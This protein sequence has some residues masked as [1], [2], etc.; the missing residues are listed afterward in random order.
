MVKVST[1]ILFLLFLIVFISDEKTMPKTEA[2]DCHKT[3]NF[4]RENRCRED[5]RNQYNGMGLCDLYTA[6]SVPKQCFCAY[7]C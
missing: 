1:I 3:W 5:C 7:K 4:K 2:K 6:P